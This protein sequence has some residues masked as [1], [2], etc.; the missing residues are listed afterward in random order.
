[1]SSCP[2]PQPTLREIK[3]RKIATQQEPA[4]EIN[5]NQST[6]SRVLNGNGTRVTESLEH[7]SKYADMHL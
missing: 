5:I 6:I 1:M 4:E 7:L 2:I 3:T